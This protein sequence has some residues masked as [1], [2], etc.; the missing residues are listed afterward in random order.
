L[1]FYLYHRK[2]RARVLKV[3]IDVHHILL[4]H[5]FNIIF[6]LHYIYVSK[7]IWQNGDPLEELI[8]TK[9]HEKYCKLDLITS[10]HEG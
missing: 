3:L 9:L 2:I 4:Y 1:I 8:T 5:I 10:L 7:Q 6:Q